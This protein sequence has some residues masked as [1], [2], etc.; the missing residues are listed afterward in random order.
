MLI[1]FFFDYFW[2]EWNYFEKIVLVYG[3]DILQ[4]WEFV[5]ERME[6]FDLVEVKLELVCEWI[7]LLMDQG[8][9][10]ILVNCKLSFFW[11]FYKYFF[12]QGEVSVDLLCK[13]IGLKNKKLFFFFLKE[14]EM[15]KLL[16]DIDFGEGFKGC[17]DCLIIEMFYVMGMCFFELIGL[18]DKDVD[19]FVFF[20]KVMGKRNKQCLIFFGDELKEMMFEY[21]DIR[22]EMIFGRLDVFFV[23]E[24]GEWFYKNLV[25]NLVKWNFLKVVMFKKCSFYVLRYIFVIM[26]LNNDVELGVVKEF[27][28]Y[29]SLVIMEIYMYIIF[30]EFK[31]VYK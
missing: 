19:F 1:D 26:M 13:I 30:E 2:Y 17:W 5:Q 21:V 31:K 23:R 10:L 25:Y 8:Y 12:R 22:N 27:L 4:L 29:S 9:I 14:S 11:L 6:K 24:N 18:D 20:L 15:N 3:E 7:V 16:D 28:G